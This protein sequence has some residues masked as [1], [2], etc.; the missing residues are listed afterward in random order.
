LSDWPT[1]APAEDL[2]KI[3]QTSKNPV[4]KTLALR[5]YIRLAGLESDRPAEETIKMYMTAMALAP[6]AGEKRM[7]LSGL[8][9]VKS[10]EALHIAAEYLADNELKQEAEAAVV[11]IAESTIRKNPQETKELL[12]KVLT[13]TTNELVREQAQRLLS[14]GK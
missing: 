4:Q 10:L 1:A 14:Q 8:S 7:V 5:G 2:L 13:G 6:G 9:N 11:K 12:Q 3:A